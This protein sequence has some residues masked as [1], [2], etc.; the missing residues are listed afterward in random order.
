MTVKC[1]PFNQFVLAIP[2]VNLKR[3]QPFRFVMVGGLST[4]AH[5]GCMAVLTVVAAMDALCATYIGAIVGAFTNYVLQR[6][7]VFQC[8]VSHDQTIVPYLISVIVVWLVNG[9][10]FWFLNEQMRL[11]AISA[12]LTTTLFV[13]AL[14]FQLQRRV[15]S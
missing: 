2:G 10:V 9:A 1:N 15:F 6:R 11:S 5:W 13:A 3:N 12:Q 8:S 4:L 7:Y 14:S